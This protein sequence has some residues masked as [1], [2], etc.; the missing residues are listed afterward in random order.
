M[1]NITYYQRNANQNHNE[2]PLHASQDGCYPKVS[3]NFLISILISSVTCSLFGNILFNLHVLVFFT[4]LF[5]F[6]VNENTS[7]L[8]VLWLEKMLDTIS[9][10]L[11]LLE[12]GLWPK[13]W[14]ILENVPRVLEKKVYSSALDG[15]CWRYLWNPFRLMY[16]LRRVSLLFPYFLFLWFI[17]VS[18][19]LKSPTI[20]VLLSIS[21]FVSVSVCLMYWSCP[22]LGA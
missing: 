10:F 14:S 16:H 4:V 3:R 1:L 9:V 17:G 12:F 5:F 6:L 20:I 11:N 15:I 21:P 8:I 22:V 7:S 13:M 19:M 18:G 2:V